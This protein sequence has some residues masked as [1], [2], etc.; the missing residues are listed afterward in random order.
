MV[1]YPAAESHEASKTNLR[2]LSEKGLKEM[3][4]IHDGTLSGS[5]SLGFFKSRE[6]AE[7]LRKELEARQIGARVQPKLSK[8]TA[9]FLVFPWPGGTDELSARLLESGFEPTELAAIDPGGCAPS[10]IAD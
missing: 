4:M 2:T 6:R 7:M 8:R 9:Y 10:G 3:W 1:Y 5:I